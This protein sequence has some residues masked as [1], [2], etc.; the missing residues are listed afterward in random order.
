MLVKKYWKIKMH[1]LGISCVAKQVTLS[2]QI[3]SLY[4]EYMVQKAKGWS[5]KKYNILLCG[6]KSS[7]RQKAKP[8]AVTKIILILEITYVHCEWV[9]ISMPTKI[10]IH[11]NKT[12][13][14]LHTPA[15][16]VYVQAILKH[17]L[18]CS[19]LSLIYID[20]FL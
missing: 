17:C 8:W 12:I 15:Q 2:C 6:Q 11:I 18:N 3:W 4:Q 10:I 14:C 19:I 9:K 20:I 16:N 5:R 7:K 13:K 1:R